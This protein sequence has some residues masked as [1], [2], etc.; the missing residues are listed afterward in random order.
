M[1]QSDDVKYDP[2]RT[3]KWCGESIS[4]PLSF[5]DI[6]DDVYLYRRTSNN[7]VKIINP[8][9]GESLPLYT[10]IENMGI[11]DYYESTKLTKEI[12]EKYY[13]KRKLKA[14]VKNNKRY[15]LINMCE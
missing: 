9:T 8:Y 11:F 1:K 12:E 7:D 13:G 3:Y 15:L 10:V 5:L 2:R 14:L 4:L 6:Y